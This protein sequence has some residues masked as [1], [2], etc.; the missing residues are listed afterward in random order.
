MSDA[1]ESFPQAHAVRMM[2]GEWQS[3]ITCVRRAEMRILM[4]CRL[5]NNKSSFLSSSLVQSTTKEYSLKLSSLVLLSL[6]ASLSLI[7]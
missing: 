5:I 1:H 3:Q 4:P 7:K 6:L 2:S